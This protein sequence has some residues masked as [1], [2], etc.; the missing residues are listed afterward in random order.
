ME[1]G[2]E[3]PSIDMVRCFLLMTFYMLG[4]CRRNAAFM[5]LGVASQASSALGLHVTEEYRHFDAEIQIVRLRTLRSLR[6]LDVIYCS[7]L[8]RSYSTAAV[9][10]EI[11][12]IAQL[13]AHIATP[14]PSALKASFEVCSIIV[15]I[16][17]QLDKPGSI[18][19]SKAEDFLNG[20]QN[21]SAT[22]PAEV[23]RFSRSTDEPLKLGDRERT[24][25]TVHVSCLYYFAV[26]LVT[27]PFLIKHLMAHMSNDTDPRATSS[28]VA[29]VSD[30]AQ[31]CVEAAMLMANMCYEALQSGVL[32]KQ[33]CILK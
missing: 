18:S 22:L 25:G 21:W 5:Y 4:A 30:L 20:L 24:I 10:T 6:V 16:T 27:R 23:R 12:A 14:R 3:D 31:A 13:Q 2:L 26:I 28:A 11:S 9:K 17:P 7:I 15:E 32:L 1:D 8:G 29:G 19:L 33:M